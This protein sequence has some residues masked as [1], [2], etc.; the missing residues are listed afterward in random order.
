[1][2]DQL[3][4]AGVVLVS[5]SYDS[6]EVLREFAASHHI[7]FR[8]L[9]DVGSRN[10][11]RLGLVDHEI[12]A[13]QAEFGI[14][15]T[16]RH[17]GVAYPSVFLL[18]PDGL[19]TQKRIQRNY[20]LRETGATLV[21]AALGRRELGVERS[22]STP[23]SGPPVQI[24]VGLDHPYYRPFQINRM[25]FD[26]RIAP[27]FHIYTEPIPPGYQSFSIDLEPAEWAVSAPQLPSDTKVLRLEGLS[28]E[29]VVFQTGFA[30][31]VPFAVLMRSGSGDA[32]VTATVR[33]QACN[34]SEC[35]PPVV[36]KFSVHLPEETL[37]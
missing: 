22:A 5:I 29:F 3:D 36:K 28:D 18:D 10:L 34:D 7:T 32:D 35:F 14:A 33:Y 17:L 16:D 24:D 25:H 13:H 26:V 30:A 8:M 20:R 9:G 19:V 11:E 27:G 23:T 2:A 12:A 37:N 15:L 6:L 31:T 4:R 21:E 1:M